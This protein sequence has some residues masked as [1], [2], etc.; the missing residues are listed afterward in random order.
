MEMRETGEREGGEGR[1]ER[2]GREGAWGVVEIPGVSL[3]TFTRY[4][5]RCLHGAHSMPVQRCVMDGAKCP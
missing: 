1:D 2:K 5:R 4:D 3:D